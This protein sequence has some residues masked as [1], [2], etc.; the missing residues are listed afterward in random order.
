[1]LRGG[2][3]EIVE[4]E[5]RVVLSFFLRHRVKEVRRSDDELAHVE[6]FLEKT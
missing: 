1:M 2:Q 3:E 4:A 6:G 5:V